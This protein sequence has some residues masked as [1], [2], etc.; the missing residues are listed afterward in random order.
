MAKKTDE[1]VFSPSPLTPH[2]GRRGQPDGRHLGAVSPLGQEGQ[3]EGLEDDGWDN[4]GGRGCQGAFGGGE[5]RGG[6]RRS[7]CRGCGCRGPRAIRG[8]SPVP[9]GEFALDFFELLLAFLS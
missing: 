9:L 4:G 3:S 2:V 6:F 8:G 7:G 5:R 1:N